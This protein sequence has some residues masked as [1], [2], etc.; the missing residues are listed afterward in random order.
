MYI[1]ISINKVGPPV[2]PYLQHQT[3][4]NSLPSS[5]QY[6]LLNLLL[7][8][9]VPYRYKLDVT[10]TG[11]TETRDT[12]LANEEGE[13]TGT[14]CPLQQTKSSNFWLPCLG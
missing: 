7:S 12:T 1:S 8:D 3:Y 11:E 14:I 5:L 2:V 6:S 10:D 9:K 4:N 13:D